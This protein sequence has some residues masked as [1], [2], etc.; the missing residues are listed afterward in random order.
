MV[1]HAPAECAGGGALGGTLTVEP[2]VWGSGLVRRCSRRLER[3]GA[4][5]GG[6]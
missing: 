6:S 1:D 3:P 4:G 5:G 2:P